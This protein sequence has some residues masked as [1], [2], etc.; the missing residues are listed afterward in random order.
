MAVDFTK[1]SNF[2]E[3]TS[4]DSVIFGANAPVLEVELNEVQQIQDMQRKRVQQSLGDMIVPVIGGSISLDS[5]SGAVSVTKCAVASKDGFSAFI[6]DVLS[7]T[8]AT[9]RYVY[10]VLT[11]TPVNGTST[12]KSYGNVNGAIITNPIIDSRSSVETSRRYVI[13]VSI[14]VNTSVPANTNTVHNVVIAYR[15]SDGSFT[16]KGGREKTIGE[17]V[18]DV[19]KQLNGLSFYVDSNNILHVTDGN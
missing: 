2:S 6:N 7:A 16:L 14:A 17:D 13:T 11:K 19:K 10:I 8:V 1:Y 12:L 9:G 18:N 5:S 4:F 15:E 3:A